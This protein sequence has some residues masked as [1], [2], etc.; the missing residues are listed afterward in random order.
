MFIVPLVRFGPC[1]DGRQLRLVGAGRE[2]WVPVNNTLPYV[3]GC[4]A[5]IQG[6]LDAPTP[7]A[8]SF[9]EFYGRVR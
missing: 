4:Q 5:L 8:R 1:G 2:P 9:G 6:Q 3:T 7:L